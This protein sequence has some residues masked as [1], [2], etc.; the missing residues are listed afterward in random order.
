MSIESEKEQQVEEKDMM[1]KIKEELEEIRKQLDSEREMKTLLLKYDIS[2]YY[3]KLKLT[4]IFILANSVPHTTKNYKLIFLL[5]FNYM[6]YK[7][8]DL[9]FQES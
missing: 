2:K 8:C 3:L 5:D 6:Q 4:L 1:M 7:M 9:F